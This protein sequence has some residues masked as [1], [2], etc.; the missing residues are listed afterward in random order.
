MLLPTRCETCQWWGP[1][2]TRILARI[3]GSIG[4]I[5]NGLFELKE[6]R[7]QPTPN[8]ENEFLAYTDSEFCCSNWKRKDLKEPS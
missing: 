3:N 4:P 5:R 2:A 6:C 8:A 1:V 7:F